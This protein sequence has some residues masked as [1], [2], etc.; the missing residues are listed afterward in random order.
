MAK[1]VA[2]TAR[3]I[4]LLALIAASKEP[5]EGVMMLTQDEG[6]EAVAAGYAAVDA[7]KTEGNT[8]A[9]SLTDA[10]RAA[11]TAGESTATGAAAASGFEIDADVPM[12]GK[13][14]RRGRSGGY[15]FEAL[16]VGQSFHV[17]PTKDD[18]TLDALLTRLSSSVSGARAKFAEAIDG[19]TEEV[20][21][22][23]FKKGDDGKYLKDEA[24]KRIVD[25]ETKTTRPKTKLTRD[26]F[27]AKVDASDPKGEGVRIW[28]VA[29]QG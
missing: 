24:G 12:P 19:Q 28:R 21:V 2:V 15:P 18:D 26:F 25:T 14:A 23:T 17:A 3:G 10:G 22:K 5:A 20:T 9:V 16:E 29:L 4:A 7:T 8:A 6:A 27:A 13:A 1:R 11:L